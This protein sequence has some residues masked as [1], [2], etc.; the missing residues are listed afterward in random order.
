MI[1]YLCVTGGLEWGLCRYFPPHTP[2]FQKLLASKTLHAARFQ[3][4]PIEQVRYITT[5][6]A[7]ILIV[8]CVSRPS[9][10]LHCHKTIWGILPEASVCSRMLNAKIFDPPKTYLRFSGCGLV[11]H[12]KCAAHP[13]PT[14]RKAS[15]IVIVASWLRVK[16]DCLE[17][18]SIPP[19]V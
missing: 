14:C 3:D 13:P 4:K 11:V 1:Y 17:G 10:C 6:F 9:A 16:I 5:I 2:P 19:G 15:D 12:I 18:P 8:F 7:M